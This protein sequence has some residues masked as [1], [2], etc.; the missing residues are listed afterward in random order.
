M[1]KREI[2]FVG[3]GFYYGGFAHAEVAML[4][5]RHVMENTELVVVD[6]QKEEDLVKKLILRKQKELELNILNPLVLINTLEYDFLLN[7]NI[8][9]T[10]TVPAKQNATC[11]NHCIAGKNKHCIQPRAPASHA[12]FFLH[13]LQN[14]NSHIESFLLSSFKLSS[15]CFW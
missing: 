5:H 11:A 8:L 9:P 4:A 13:F 6:S 10:K 2:F 1:K 7:T 15:G 3:V 12:L 14:K